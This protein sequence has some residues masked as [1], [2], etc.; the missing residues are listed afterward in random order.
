MLRTKGLIISFICMSTWCAATPFQF[1]DPQ[2][3]MQGIVADVVIA[4]HVDL[5]AYKSS[6]LPTNHITHAYNFLKQFH[7]DDRDF[8]RKGGKPAYPL[9][10][11]QA[12]AVLKHIRGNYATFTTQD[13]VEKKKADVVI[14]SGVEWSLEKRLHSFKKFLDVGY[15]C[16]NVYFLS[17]NQD[18]E[19]NVKRVLVRHE[20]LFKN[21]KTHLIQ[22]NYDCWSHEDFIVKVSPF[23]SKEFYLVSDPEYALTL[24]EACI[25]YGQKHGLTCLG[26]FVRPITNDPDEYS[27]QDIK[28]Y[29]FDEFL[30]D[31]DDQLRTAAYA[32]LNML[33]HQVAQE[34]QL[35]M[36]DYKAE[37][38]E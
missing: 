37:S 34:I 6:T 13:P 38:N 15:S 12:R 2:G 26:A 32:S 5:E 18:L 8:Y 3:C 35:F 22:A 33:A 1:I 36:P 20:Q 4:L 27:Q 14:F 23:I 19:N 9:A 11:T 31:P 7:H 25:V 17:R 28:A 10:V 21:I 24:K 30:S 29:K 16:D